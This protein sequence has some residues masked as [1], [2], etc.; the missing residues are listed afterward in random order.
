MKGKHIIFLGVLSVLL[1]GCK[2]APKPIYQWDG[3]QD[4]LYQYYKNDTSPAEQIA[5]LQKLVEKSRATSQPVP[6]GVHAQLGL[7][8]SNTGQMDSAMAE[9]NTEKKLFPE[10]TVYIDFL[11]KKD[12]GSLK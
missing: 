3:Y 9:F 4:T 10:S 2:T 8:Y 6:P 5:S 7:L 1:V 11:T 12:K